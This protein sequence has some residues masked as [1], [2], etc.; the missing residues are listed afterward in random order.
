MSRTIIIGIAWLQ[1]FVV[2]PSAIATATQTRKSGRVRW[3]SFL[4]AT[5]YKELLS[6]RENRLCENSRRR[7]RRYTYPRRS[8]VHNKTAGERDRFRLRR[9][10]TAATVFVANSRLY[11]VEA[12]SC[13]CEKSSF[14]RRP[15]K[16]IRFAADDGVAKPEMDTTF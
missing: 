15:N 1:A 10:N 4:N 5:K 16:I 2:S 7:R 14:R 8:F 13:R 3:R 11:T 12:C 6:K 9:L